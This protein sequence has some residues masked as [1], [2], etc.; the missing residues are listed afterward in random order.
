MTPDSAC[1]FCGCEDAAPCV[2]DEGDTCSWIASGLCSF[3]AHLVPEAALA[4]NAELAHRLAI[5][6]PHYSPAEHADAARL[7]AE[8]T[9]RKEAAQ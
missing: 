6:L 1:L 2:D 4:L 5:A 9:S 3:C 7:Y 8:S